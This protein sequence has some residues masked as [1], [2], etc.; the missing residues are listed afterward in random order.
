MSNL[1]LL[2]HPQDVTTILASAMKQRVGQGA[3]RLWRLMCIIGRLSVTG[4][5]DIARSRIL[6][7]WPSFASQQ[8][9]L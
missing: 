6:P 2:Q 4:P 1:S 3:R 7:T 5:L 8:I 9:C